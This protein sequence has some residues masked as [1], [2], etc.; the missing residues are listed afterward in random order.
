M[1]ITKLTRVVLPVLLLSVVPLCAT[2]QMSPALDRFSISAGAFNSIPQIRATVGSS[3]GSSS[4]SDIDTERK[5]IARVSGDLLLGDHHGISFDAFRSSQD[6]SSITQSGFGSGPFGVA[7]AANVKLGFDLDV[8]RIGYRYWFGSGNTV[9]GF[10]AGLGYYHAS[11]KTQVSIAARKKV[12]SVVYY[13]RDSEEAVAPMLEL[14]IRHSLSSNL[15]LFV[16]AS[17]I[18]K[19]GRGVRGSIYNAALGVEWFPLKNLGISAAYSTTDVDLKRDGDGVQGL[20]VKFH[21]PVVAL[22][23]RF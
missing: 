3:Q 21:G 19:G 13:A 15:R 2:A 11:L 14:G 10:G 4:T 1:K 12:P 6:Y 20:G 7:G 9:L 16:D 8:T 23:V 22:K 18:H 5:T 17:G